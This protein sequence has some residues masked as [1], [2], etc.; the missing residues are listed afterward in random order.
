M[1][2]ES[3]VVRD[4][5]SKVHDR[6]NWDLRKG[7]IHGIIGPSGEG[8]SY[9]LKIMLGL[10]PYTSGKILDEEGGHW[11]YS[12]KRVGVQFQSNGLLNNM[13]IGE[14]VMMPLIIKL[15]M[16]S[17]HA[18]SIARHYLKLVGLQDQVFDYFPLECSG[19]MQKRAALAVTLALEPHTLFLD[20]PTAGL[21]C[22]VLE[23]YDQ[24][25]LDLSKTRK[26]TIVMVTHDFSR[27]AKIADRVSVLM[28]GKMYTGTF[29]QLQKCDNIMVRE[30]LGSYVRTIATF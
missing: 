20:E 15:N 13:T 26:M 18:A 25:L 19:G 16:P 10:A 3:I 21:D 11:D 12:T 24:L 9:F 29:P 5:V 14:N 23:N 22:L 30:F 7:E 6:L 28:C 27:L 1:A 8:K 2:Q 4:L 17:D